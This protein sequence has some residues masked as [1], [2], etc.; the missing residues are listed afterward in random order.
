MK[1][2]TPFVAPLFVICIL[3]ADGF[4][5]SQGKLFW[6][7]MVD[8]RLHLVIKGNTVEHRTITGREMPDGVYSFTAPLPD[9]P[10]FVRV[11]RLRGRSKEIDVIQQPAPGNDFVAIV[12]I[13]DPSGGARE[14]NLEIF[15]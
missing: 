5:Q 2:T 7:G 3:F 6:R 1:R 8:G 15:W 11:T 14:Y 4:A 9:S 12:D 13:H 10:V